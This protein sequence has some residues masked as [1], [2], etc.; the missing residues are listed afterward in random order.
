MGALG[1]SQR[2][3]G[4]SLGVAYE[5]CRQVA[6]RE[7]RN[8]YY[9]FRLLPTPRRRAIYAAYAFSRL[10]DDVADGE[11]PPG[12]KAHLLTQYRRDLDRCLAGQ[13]QGPVFTALADAIH[14]YS[15]PPQYFGQLID[16]VEMDLERRRYQTFAELYSYCQRVAS[17]IGLITIEICGYREPALAREAA[18]DL[19]V[20]LQLTNI[21]RDV[22]EDGDRGRI[23]IPLEEM[24]WFDYTE[25][26][27]LQ[28]R[29]TAAFHKLMEFQVR[30]ALVYFQRG[31]RL[32]PLLPLRSRPC[33]AVLAGLYRAILERI[34]T[35]PSAVLQERVGLTAAE[36]LAL[37]GKLWLQ[38]LLA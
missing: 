33:V 21:L 8:F 26:D 36:K 14:R 17:V 27:L 7:A 38:S 6:R 37:T 9:G 35:H 1:L 24:Q 29:A 20:A 15:I 12:E 16:G 10:C 30:R 18:V 28:A 23:Y 19:G 3:Q 13:P 11:L 34:A 5:H 32:L 31:N 2:G 4:A 25:G 22:K